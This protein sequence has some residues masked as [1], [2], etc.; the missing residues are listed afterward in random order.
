[1]KELKFSEYPFHQPNGKKIIAKMEGFVNELK[2]AKIKAI[3]DIINNS[4][5]NMDE[6]YYWSLTDGIDFN[7]ERIRSELLR[8]GKIETIEE[9]PTVCGGLFP[10]YKRLIKKQEDESTIVEQNFESIEPSH[11]HR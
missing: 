1:M 9:I 10:T 8:E 11:K 5:V 4:G 3:S 7:L 6:I 2:A